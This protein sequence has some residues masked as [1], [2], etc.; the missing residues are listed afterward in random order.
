MERLET[1][2]RNSEALRSDH[3]NLFHDLMVLALEGVVCVQTRE[4]CLMLM[5]LCFRVPQ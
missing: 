3:I 2:F 4:S 5:L 1:P